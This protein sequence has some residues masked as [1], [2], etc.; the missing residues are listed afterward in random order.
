MDT[1]EQRGV[2]GFNLHQKIAQNEQQRRFLLVENI[3][4]LHQ[5]LENKLYK[6]VLGD[7]QAEWAAYLGQ[8]EV[9]YTRNKIYSYLRV[10]KDLVLKHQL[11]FNQ[12]V[13][14]P[15]SRLMDLVGIESKVTDLP[16]WLGKA[17]LLPSRDWRDEIKELK[18][19]P[20]SD[21]CE[22]KKLDCYHICVLCGFKKKV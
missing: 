6:E 18:G 12:I 15:I 3:K 10:Y 19:L 9:F 21:E 16:D 4:H 2:E 1:K 5:M 7:N 11:Q 17:R 22:H 8:I 14:I 13:D 20:T